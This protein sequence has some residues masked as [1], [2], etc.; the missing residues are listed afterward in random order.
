M[1]SLTNQSQTSGGKS[2]LSPPPP[3]KPPKRGILKGPRLSISSITTVNEDT[4][5]H[6]QNGNESENNHNSSI[7]LVRNT[8][9]NEVIAYQNIQSSGSIRG[10]DDACS[11]EENSSSYLL[12]HSGGLHS[13]QSDRHHHQDSKL[14]RVCIYLNKCFF[15]SPRGEQLLLLLHCSILLTGCNKYQSI[16]RLIDRH[17]KFKFCNSPIQPITC[18]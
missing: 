11:E 12:G 5:A 13:Q 2:I 7:L 14:L 15:S 1:T 3:P 8:L 10:G 18:W 16:S 6:V 9:Q 4:C 17:N